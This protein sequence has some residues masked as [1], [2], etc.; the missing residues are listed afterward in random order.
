[1][2]GLDRFAQAATGREGDRFV[3]PATSAVEAT[4]R[5]VP[6]PPWSPPS[7]LRPGVLAGAIRPCRRPRVRDGALTADR[8][9]CPCV[10]AGAPA[11]MIPLIVQMSLRAAPF[12]Q[13]N[14]FL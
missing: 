1:M 12:L 14:R 3:I 4:A 9:D 8:P 7:G 13:G 6:A 10:R 11:I 2:A 5:D